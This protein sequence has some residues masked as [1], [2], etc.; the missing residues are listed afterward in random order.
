MVLLCFHPT[1][2]STAEVETA[3]NAGTTNS[4]HAAG[5]A[6]G[7]R[8]LICRLIQQSRLLKKQM[9]S[10]DAP[11]PLQIS[12]AFTPQVFLF[13]DASHRSPSALHPL[14]YPSLE[15]GTTAATSPGLCNCRSARHQHKPPQLTPTAVCTFKVSHSVH[16]HP[17][18]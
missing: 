1:Q 13:G 11:E 14:S 15:I 7:D 18:A 12:S 17:M 16:L 8:D 4:R 3:R 5:A 10:T 6:K 9:A 2:T